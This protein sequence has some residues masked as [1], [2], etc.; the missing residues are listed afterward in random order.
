[1]TKPDLSPDVLDT[2]HPS[3]GA[4]LLKRA[5]L[6]IGGGF[7]LIF[8]VGMIAGYTG[9]VIEHGGP[10]LVD[11]AMLTGMLLAGVAIGYGIWR[12]WPRGS[13]EPEAPRVKGARMILLAAFILCLSLGIIL[14]VKDD[15]AASIVSNG[16]INPA[17]AMLALV[18]W[19]FAMPVLTWLWWR[20]VDE[21]E[22][23]A[24]R[25]GGLVAVHAYLFIAPTWWIASRAG[26]VPHQDPMIVLLIVSVVWCVVWFVRRYL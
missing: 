23:V 7:V 25:D 19:N 15:G 2:D 13:N 18:L 22:A 24:Y 16:P 11:I 5:L 1:M 8:L 21:H 26:W 14:G 3:D 4:V 20:K 9:A 17:M 10:S 6:G 12:F